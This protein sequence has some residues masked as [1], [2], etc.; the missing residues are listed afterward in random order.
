MHV[1]G[2]GLPG[3]APDS[4]A[5]PPR[6]RSR[7]RPHVQSVEVSGDEERHGER[8]GQRGAGTA[9]R[10]YGPPGR[11]RR[12]APW[13]RSAGFAQSARLLEPP[14]RRARWNASTSA[15]STPF[16][17]ART[18]DHLHFHA[19]SMRSPRPRP[20]LQRPEMRF[21]LARGTCCVST[22]ARAAFCAVD[23]VATALPSAAT[24]IRCAATGSATA[25]SAFGSASTALRPVRTAVGRAATAVGPV[26]TPLGPSGGGKR[27][28]W[29]CR[30][31]VNRASV[32]SAPPATRVGR[33]L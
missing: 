1:Y 17:N 5:D 20:E 26:A 25:S 8:F 4:G 21:S 24:A 13:S 12:P 32:R 22:A 23:S 15:R 16:P 33:G 9:I 3:Q 31:R 14:A 19:P 6:A 28:C 29:V 2:N 30:G 7:A 18:P 11:S 27:Q 10:T